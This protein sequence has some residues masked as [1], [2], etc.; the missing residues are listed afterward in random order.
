MTEDHADLLSRDKGKVKEAVKRYLA[1]KV[2]NDWEFQWPPSVAATTKEQGDRGEAGAG[3]DAPSPRLETPRLGSPAQVQD[4][5]SDD[6]GYQNDGTSDDEPSE[7]DYDD[8]NNSNHDAVSVYSV[9]SEDPTHYRALLEWDSDAP[10]EHE[11]TPSTEHSGGVGYSSAEPESK[12]E[13]QARKRREIRKEMEYN[14]GLACF[15]AR[16]AAWT[17][18]RTVRVRVK[19][20]NPTP[21]SAHSPRR[22]FFRRSYSNT[23][24]SQDA[25]SMS[26]PSAA[27]SSDGTAEKAI[28]GG[29]RDKESGHKHLKK[30][31]TSQSSQHSDVG[32]YP[33][34]TIV[35]VSA[36]I[37]PPTNPLRASIQ[38]SHYLQLYDKLIVNSLT[39]SCPINLSDM[40]SAC[41]AGWK[42]DGEWPPRPAL[43]VDPAF[44]AYGGAVRKKKRASFGAPLDHANTSSGRRLSLTGLLSRD[45]DGDSRSTKSVRQS[46]QKA[47]GLG[48]HAEVSVA[49]GART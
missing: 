12:L 3:D 11:T 29:S 42:R 49:G 34:E 10:V 9:V 47:F 15:E 30:D 41:V 5:L 19:P 13:R 38:P 28:E 37:L 2:R 26:A 43:P 7:E 44:A 18:A 31:S 17:Q 33:V 20:E 32:L 36:P 48:A 23:V 40:L 21:S 27:S 35:P 6:E 16:R 39:P 8:G 14:D 45:K 1:T 24:A 22:F 46:L 25:R 4:E